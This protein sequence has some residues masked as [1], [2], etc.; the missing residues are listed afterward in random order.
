MYLQLAS[1]LH[2]K[3]L[4][5]EFTEYKEIIFQQAI[6]KSRIESFAKNAMVPSGDYRFFY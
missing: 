5:V 1:S 3:M 2:G 4:V 6:D